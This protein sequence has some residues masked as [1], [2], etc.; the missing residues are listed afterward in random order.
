MRDRLH[1]DPHGLTFTTSLTSSIRFDWHLVT[2]SLSFLS[3][4]IFW[5]CAMGDCR[6]GSAMTRGCRRP[7]HMSPCASAFADVLRAAV[8]QNSRTSLPLPAAAPAHVPSPP[9]CVSPPCVP[10]SCITQGRRCPCPPSPLHACARRCPTGRLPT[11]LE[12]ADTSENLQSITK[13]TGPLQ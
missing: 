7:A 8:L 9:P 13:V 4:E 10:P 1:A 6:R 11:S 12:D 5:S 3:T 2:P